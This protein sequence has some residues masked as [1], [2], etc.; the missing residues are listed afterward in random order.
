MSHADVPQGVIDRYGVA[1]EGYLGGRANQHWVVRRSGKRCVLRQ[2]QQYPQG[3]EGYELDVLR[4]LDDLGWPTPIAVADPIEV[5]DRSWCLFRW[6]PG[7]S[8]ETR[9]AP[10]E[11]RWR[12]RLLAQLHAD[13]ARLGDLGQRQGF[14]TATEVVEDPRLVPGLRRY[15]SGFPEEARIMRWHLDRAR[16]CFARLDTASLPL[17][18]LHGDFCHRN[19]LCQN[20]RLTGVIDFEVTHLNHRV[21]EF[22]HA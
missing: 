19:L 7:H 13:T 18:V 8:P 17:L 1:V 21:S 14:R 20:D 16:D 15:A 4:R 6:L 9:D 11:L 5:D 2:Y 3:E 12:G 22:A 10:D